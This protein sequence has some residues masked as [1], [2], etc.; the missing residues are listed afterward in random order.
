[1]KMWCYESGQILDT[2]PS[3]IL[4]KDKQVKFII[5]YLFSEIKKKKLYVHICFWR[6]LVL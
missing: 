6:V 5:S 4:L 1:M 3:T 2:F